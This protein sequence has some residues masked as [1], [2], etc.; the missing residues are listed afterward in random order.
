MSV[1]LRGNSMRI[2]VPSLL[3]VL[4]VSVGYSQDI[5]SEIDKARGEIAD[6]KPLILPELVGG[7]GLLAGGSAWIVASLYQGSTSGALQT[8]SVGGLVLELTGGLVIALAGA[9]EQRT[10]LLTDRIDYVGYAK[11][12]DDEKLSVLRGQFHVGM[13]EPSFLL[14]AGTPMDYADG[15]T[16]AHR[17]L[18]YPWGSANSDD[19]VITK[20][21]KNDSIWVQN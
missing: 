4:V 5:Q 7:W 21:Q 12:S 15:P 2:L 8:A 10:T 3:F 9:S 13:Q 14:A 19:G 18:I 11:I 17:Q 6:T 1:R 20:I 16:S